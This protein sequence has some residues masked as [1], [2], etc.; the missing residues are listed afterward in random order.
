MGRKQLLASYDDGGPWDT[1]FQTGRQIY[2]LYEAKSQ[3]L[4]I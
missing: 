1:H 4:E 3:C 2:R